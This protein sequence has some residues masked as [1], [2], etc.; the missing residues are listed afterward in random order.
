MILRIRNM[1][2]SSQ[3]SDYATVGRAC[4][5]NA[6]EMEAEESGIQDHLQRSAKFEVS[7]GYMR[8]GLKKHDC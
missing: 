5:P 7:I 2:L 6:S 8:S 1:F 3:R 4:D